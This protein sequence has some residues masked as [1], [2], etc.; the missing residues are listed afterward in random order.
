M[1][2]PTTPT[3]I[4][5]PCRHCNVVIWC[6]HDAEHP[7]LCC[8]CFDLSFGMPLA[9]LNEAR[10]TRGLPPIPRPWPRR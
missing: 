9:R 7:G 6:S 2:Q 4:R 5:P 10:A 3:P 8:D 1:S